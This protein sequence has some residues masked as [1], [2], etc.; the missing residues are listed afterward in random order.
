MIQY[1][2]IHDDTIMIHVIIFTS[3]FVGSDKQGS[4]IVIFTISK[5]F[6]GLH[7]NSTFLCTLCTNEVSVLVLVAVCWW[8]LS[9]ELPGSSWCYTSISC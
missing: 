5:L 4:I 1:H 8:S 2:T 6:L 9:S 7:S 3:E